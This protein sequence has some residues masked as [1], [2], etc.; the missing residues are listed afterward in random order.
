MAKDDSIEVTGISSRPKSEELQMEIYRTEAEMS[1]TLH[2]IEERL[3]PSRLKEQAAQTAMTWAVRG[4]NT[5]NDTYSKHKSLFAMIGAGLIF[6]IGN[7]MRKS[8]KPEVRRQKRE[9]QRMELIAK[10]IADRTTPSPAAGMFSK[11][12]AVAFGTAIGT[13][14]S[15][16]RKKE[17]VLH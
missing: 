10:A 16:S 17:A 11:G 1:E 9:R 5:I 3:S 14:L 4:A 13:A 12:L 8:R 15:Q 7:K 2:S 6:L